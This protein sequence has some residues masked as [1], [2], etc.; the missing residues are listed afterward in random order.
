MSQRDPFV[1]FRKNVTE[2]V[3]LA[4]ASLMVIGLFTGHWLFIVGSVGVLFV[5]PLVALLFGDRSAIEEWWGEEKAEQVEADSP[6]ENPLE[7]LK[8]RYAEGELSEAEF[9]NR[10]SGLL[11]T[12]NVET[13]NLNV[14]Q[15][16]PTAGSD[17]GDNYEM[18]T[19]KN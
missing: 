16:E 8:R 12:E 6:Q 13:T 11:Q 9:E 15:R 17:N 10:V 1:R 5:T 7:T 18:E 19:E 4:F 3:G 14:D 2:V